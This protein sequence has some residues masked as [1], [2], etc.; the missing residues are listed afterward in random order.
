MEWEAIAVDELVARFSHRNATLSPAATATVFT[1]SDFT[2]FDPSLFV[3]VMVSVPAGITP[4]TRTE[5]VSGP[6]DD[7]GLVPFK[8]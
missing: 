2:A 3:K 5:Q 4:L 6:L 8:I 1:R 7:C